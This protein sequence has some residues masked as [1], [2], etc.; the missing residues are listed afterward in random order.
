MPIGVNI[1]SDYCR[2]YISMIKL[3]NNIDRANSWILSSPSYICPCIFI[4]LINAFVF[5][6]HINPLTNFPRGAFEFT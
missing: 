4:L 5:F 3:M 1:D 6:H 2:L